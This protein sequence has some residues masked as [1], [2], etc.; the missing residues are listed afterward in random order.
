M[1]F[2]LHPILSVILSF[3]V[4]LSG[5]GAA[6]QDLSALARLDSARSSVRAEGQGLAIDLHLSQAVPYRVFNLDNPPR[7]VAD[8]R[9]VA[10]GHGTRAALMPRP[11]AAVGDLRFGLYRPGWSRMVV[12]L[13][14]PLALKTATMDT[15]P[16]TGEATVR[17]R[18]APV[19]AAQF[20]HLSGAPRDRGWGLPTA[21]ASRAPRHRQNG[22]RPLMVVLDPG[23]GGIDPGAEHGSLHEADIVLTF[24]RELKETLLRQ[25][26]FDVLLTRQEDIF[27]P[28]EE[29]LSIARA[30]GADVFIS[31]HADALS[32]GR[33]R[34]A[35][36]YTLS[37]TASDEA[38]AK[39]A[40]RHDRSDLLAGV[41]L[42]GQDDVVATVLMDMARRETQ[43]RAD[44][45]ADDLVQGL[46]QTL[47]K[48]HKPPHL[49][50]SFSV[51]KAADIPS[52][53]IELGFL[54]NP[55]DR[56]NL[57]SPEWRAQAARGIVIALERWAREDAAQAPLLRH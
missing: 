35:T 57:T 19:S 47:V 10:W 34:G 45:L 9:E 16:E 28:L 15:D 32:E 5:G 42:A 26:N 29:R 13:A 22:D 27:V 50:A 1:S 17:L 38:S 56:K 48:L 4:L 3:F 18:L 30:A 49:Q 53:L 52:V 51:L 7:L 12:D 11:L 6:A 25:G 24:A 55:Q 23:H 2:R 21:A 14:A 44:A 40:E 20:A 41:D 37:A 43:P 31:L 8:F 46:R 33:A 36:V 54:S 39:L